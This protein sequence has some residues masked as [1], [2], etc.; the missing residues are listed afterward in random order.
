[1][2]IPAAARAQAEIEV[3]EWLRVDVRDNGE[4]VL[5]AEDPLERYAGMFTGLY[6]R[7]EVGRLL[8]EWE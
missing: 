1:M 7:D 3:G 8:D 4:I 6:P 2:T 5:G